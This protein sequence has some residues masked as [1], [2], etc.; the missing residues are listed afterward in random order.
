[1]PEYCAVLAPDSAQVQ[2]PPSF[3]VWLSTRTDMRPLHVTA[4]EPPKLCALPCLSLP[5][6]NTSPNASR[7]LIFPHM[8]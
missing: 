5:L 7:A 8:R 1:M 6:K 3:V 2:T 4:Y